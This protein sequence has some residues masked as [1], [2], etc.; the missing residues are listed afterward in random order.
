[1]QREQATIIDCVLALTQ[2]GSVGV[3]VRAHMVPAVLCIVL[4][5]DM[6]HNNLLKTVVK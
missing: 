2:Q 4:E 3:S 6:K 1:M 5:N